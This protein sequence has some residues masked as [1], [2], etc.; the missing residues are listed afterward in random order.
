MNIQS[1]LDAKGKLEES[2]GNIIRKH[3]YDFQR[4]TGAAVT[5]IDV[6]FI[7]VT[8]WGG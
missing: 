6:D 7:D 8:K 2:I 3:I 4:N 1:L 5:G